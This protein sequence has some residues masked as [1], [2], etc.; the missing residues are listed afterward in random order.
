MSLDSSQLSSPEVV[1]SENKKRS[2]RDHKRTTVRFTD[3]EFSRITEEAKLS[4]LSIPNLLKKSHFKRKKLQL[5]L[6]DVDRHFF[7]TEI[8]RIGNNVN[9][10]ARRVNSGALEGWFSELLDVARKISEL[11]QMAAGAYGL[12]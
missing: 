1:T 9:Q 10:I 2:P 8:R 6:S 11:H 3:E 5:L 4:G 12:R 7:C